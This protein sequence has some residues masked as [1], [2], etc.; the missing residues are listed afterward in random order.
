MALVGGGWAWH[1]FFP[2]IKKI[3]TS[4][5][6]LVAAGWSCVLLGL[7]YWL[8]DIK[9]WKGWT[10]PFIWVGSNPITLYMLGGMGLFRTVAERLVTKAEP[11]GSWLASAASF[12]AMMAL[13][14]WLHRKEV[15]IRV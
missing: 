12:L 5:F 10:P 1:P 2:V 11:S 8:I 13:A 3:W 6:V 14:R 4:S 9:G 7:F 15:F